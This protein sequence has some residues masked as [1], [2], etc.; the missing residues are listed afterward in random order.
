MR[1][2]S[3]S[4]R[5]CSSSSAS[6]C[7][8]SHGTSSI[9]CRNVSSSRCRR[10]TRSAAR[11]PESVSRSERLSG[12]DSRLPSSNRLTMADAD[13]DETPSSWAS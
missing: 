10:T 8:S 3:R 7:T 4:D 9:R 1:S 13:G 2:S 5:A 6:A 11:S 12:R